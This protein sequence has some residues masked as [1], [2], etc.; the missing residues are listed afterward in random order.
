MFARVA[1]WQ[2]LRATSMCW[3]LPDLMRL[4]SAAMIEFE[5]YNPVVRSVTA[6]PTLTLDEV[7]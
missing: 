1:T 5:V 4:S 2:S 6:T 3:P 7:N